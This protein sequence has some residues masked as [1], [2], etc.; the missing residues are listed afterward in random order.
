MVLRATTE[1]VS[2]APATAR[3]ASAIHGLGAHANRA[4]AIPQLQAPTSITTPGRGNRVYEPES[5]EATT[6]PTAMAVRNSPSVRGSP[7]NRS[8]F[9]AGN[10]LIGIES[11]VTARSVINAPRITGVDT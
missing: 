8:A 7:P 11:T 9:S 10:R 5:T 2:A 6:P 3:N 1:T 4:S